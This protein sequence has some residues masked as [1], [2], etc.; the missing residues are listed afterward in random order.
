M[1]NLN[2]VLAAAAAT[3]V[4]LGATAS[5]A[6][7]STAGPL[8][9]ERTAATVPT[10]GGAAAVPCPSGSKAIGGG[11]RIKAPAEGFAFGALELYDGGDGDTDADDGFRAGVYNAGTEPG[12]MT[13]VAICLRRGE[14]KLVIRTDAVSVP[15]VLAGGVARAYCL[16]GTDLVGGGAAVEGPYGAFAQLISSGPGESDP[17]GLMGWEMKAT[18]PVGSAREMVARAS[19][20]PEGMRQVRQ[21][22]KQTSLAAGEI[23]AIKVR[24]PRRLHA[25]AGGAADAVQ[26][27]GSAP[28]D[29]PDA[30]KAPDD[31]WRVRLRN[32]DPAASQPVEARVIC[33]G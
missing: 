7:A 30:G 1:R 13:T 32:P 5:A 12:S 33:L 10:I 17:P 24:C 20:L 31:G 21:V 23:R 29:G 22:R 6:G 28:V 16:A 3:I 26:I 27:L 11:G 18:K 8:S 25:G 19:C 14:S 15:A 4:A 2:H 9:Y